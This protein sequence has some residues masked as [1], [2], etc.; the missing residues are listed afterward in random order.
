MNW[1][2]AAGSLAAVLTLAGIAWALKLGGGTIASEEAAIEAAEQALSGFE[3]A[4]AV[5][6]TDRQAAVVQGRDGSTALLKV[7]GARIVAR[8]SL[9]LARGIHTD[10]DVHIDSGDPGFG[11]LILRGAAGRRDA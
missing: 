4:S 3:G 2:L 9:G 7:K 11:T 10:G 5:V 6:G 8:H 1:T